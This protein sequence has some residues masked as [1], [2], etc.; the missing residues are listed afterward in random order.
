MTAQGSYLSLS[1]KE[2]ATSGTYTGP[3]K[4]LRQR[5]QPLEIP[6]DCIRNLCDA[7]DTSFDERVSRQELYLYIE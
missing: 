2:V 3:P 5:D 7:M 1:M 4:Y 6:M